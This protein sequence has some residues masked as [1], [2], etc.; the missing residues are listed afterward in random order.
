MGV[1]V[2]HG[3]RHSGKS[4]Y[5]FPQE[6][7]H[8]IATIRHAIHAAAYASA[9]FGF[10]MALGA[11]STALYLLIR[12]ITVGYGVEG[13]TSVIVSLWFLFGILFLN[14]GVL[15]LYL[16]SVFDEVK[17]RPPFVIEK[18]TFDQSA[19]ITTI[20]GSSTE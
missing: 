19:G 1:Q 8:G 7:R 11:A 17:D 18:T 3:E 20:V 10:L 4:S 6:A 5:S 16:G 2:P 14:L 9:T 13:W 12:K 15:G